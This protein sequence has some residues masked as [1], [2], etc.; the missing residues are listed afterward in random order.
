MCMDDTANEQ[1]IGWKAHANRIRS[2][3][4]SYLIAHWKGEISLGVSFWING[5]LL[6]GVLRL[7]RLSAE[8]FVASTSYLLWSVWMFRSALVFLVAIKIW[9]L[10]GTWRSARRA[11]GGWASAAIFCVVVGA[12]DVSYQVFTVARTTIR[13]PTTESPFVEKAEVTYIASARAVVVDGP[14][15]RGIAQRVHKAFGRH[16]DAG[17]LVLQSPGG[18]VSAGAQLKAFLVSRPDVVVIADGLCASACTMAF[19]GGKRRLMTQGAMLGFHRA[20][21]LNDDP[22]ADMAIRDAAEELKASMRQL[23]ASNAFIAAAFA[24]EGDELYLPNMST[25]KLNGIVDGWIR[26]LAHMDVVGPMAPPPDATES[27]PSRQEPSGG[28]N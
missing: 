21:S 3:V 1:A 23:G 6:N 15:D 14:F 7:I 28:V 2:A 16:P 25:L 18:F 19:L 5:V 10:V 27:T 20:S 24:K 13:A 8:R 9:Q 26:D 11:K 12:A 22:V 4:R 17:V